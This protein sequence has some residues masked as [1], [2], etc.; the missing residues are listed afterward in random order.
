VKEEHFFDEGIALEGKL[1]GIVL[2]G[3][4]RFVS[5]KYRRRARSLSLA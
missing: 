4:R 3:L 1:V 5:Q 2:P